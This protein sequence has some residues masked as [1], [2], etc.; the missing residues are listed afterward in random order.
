MCRM[1]TLNSLRYTLKS[2]E[3]LIQEDKIKLLQQL[4]LTFLQARVYVALDEF[5]ILSA[6]EI[7]KITHIDRSNI[8]RIII[9]LQSLGIVTRRLTKRKDLF[10]AMP[11]KDGIQFLL[12]RKNKEYSE[13]QAQVRKVIDD[14][15]V[16]RKESVEENNE[17]FYLIPEGKAN[18]RAFRNGMENASSSVDDIIVWKGF[19]NALHNGVQNYINALKRGVK[20][21]YITN[22]PE[23]LVT[24]NEVFRDIQKM[25]KIGSFEVRSITTPPSCVFAVFDKREA[26]ICTLPV[27]NPLETPA[28]WSNNPTLVNLAQTYFELL[29][30]NS[31]KILG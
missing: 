17:Y 25:K 2:N 7:S 16:D 18:L 20:I 12:S 24:N 21:R 6:K 5:G 28:L 1:K 23:K 26:C 27:P 9:R 31:K 13:I 10:A 11:L 4:G 8:Y 30:F 29:W 19:V 22:L 15:K 14:I 3:M